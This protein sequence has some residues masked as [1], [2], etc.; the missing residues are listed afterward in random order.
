MTKEITWR[1]LVVDDKQADSI[2]ELVKDNNVLAPPNNVVVVK[3]KRFRDA[4]PLLNQL[5]IDLVILDLNDEE[6]G[7]LPLDDSPLAG[8]RIFNQIRQNRF[9]PIVFYT[10][11]PNKAG[12][13]NHPYVQIVKRGRPRKLR[14]AIDKIFETGLPQLIKHLEEEQRAY[15]WKHIESYWDAASTTYEK[16]DSVFLL[17]RR[18]GNVL[19]RS[20]VEDFLISQNL[21]PPK[22]DDSVYPIEIYVYPSVNPKLQVGDILKSKY[23]KKSKY[24]MVMTPSCDVEQNKVTDVVLAACFLLSDQPEYSAIRD[25]LSKEQEPSKGI[26][27]DLV[28]LIGNN[29]NAKYKP[30]EAEKANEEESKKVRFQPDRYCFLP[31]TFFIPDLVVDFQALMPIAIDKIK[32]GHRVASLDAPFAE[33][34]SSRFARY[35]GRLGTPDLNKKFVSNKILE[36]IRSEIA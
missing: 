17:A 31:G 3:C 36:V 8:V 26:M 15:M 22:E 1:F 24:W 23:N 19:K 7:I 10:A 9:V 32:S 12:D 34:Y 16:T 28:I 14:D 35:Y 30:K 18:L 29:R 4:V 6:D 20:S 5:R 33:A 25:Y 21:I 27:E 2:E 13:L 11:Y